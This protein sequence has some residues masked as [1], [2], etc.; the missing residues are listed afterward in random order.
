MSA[1]E[2]AR[3]IISEHQFAAMH[4]GAIPDRFGIPVP[5][6]ARVVGS[7]VRG[8]EDDPEGVTAYL[9]APGS[10]EQIRKRFDDLFGARGYKPKTQGGFPGH[11]GGFQ[12]TMMPMR[13]AQGAMYC[14]GEEGPFYTLGIGPGDPAPVSVMWNAGQM[15]WNPCSS[16]QPGHPMQEMEEMPSLTAP[17]GVMMQGGGGGGS[18]GAWYAQGIAFT[19]MPAR[20]LLDHFAKELET[21]RATLIAREDGDSASWGRWKMPT[22]DL[23]SIVGVI[24]AHPE[25]RLLL[26][27]TYS[28]KQQGRQVRMMTGNWSSSSFRLG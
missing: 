28:P 26:R 15:G 2:L 19:A 17:P 9:E 22:K 11:G 6:D 12:H 23:E 3:R 27:Y 7:V 10:A 13:M 18:P 4:V 1:E 16:R 5:A 20:G 8:P 21:G 25:M 24:A 14:A